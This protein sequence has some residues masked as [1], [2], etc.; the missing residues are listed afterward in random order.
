MVCFA[1]NNSRY[2]FAIPKKGTIMDCW[3][4]EYNLMDV[5]Y[6]KIGSKEYNI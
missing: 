5:N 3:G 2:I 1:Y 4:K 6:A